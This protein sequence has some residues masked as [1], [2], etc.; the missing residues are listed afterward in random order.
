MRVI[1]VTVVDALSLVLALT[2]LSSLSVT[3]AV[4]VAIAVSVVAFLVDCCISPHRHGVAP[5]KHHPELVDVD[6][7]PSADLEDPERRGAVPVGEHPKLDLCTRSLKDLDRGLLLGD[8]EV[9]EMLG[10]AL[11]PVQRAALIVDK[12]GHLVLCQVGVG[13]KKSD[14]VDH[15]HA[16]DS[17]AGLSA[18]LSEGMY[19]VGPAVEGGLQDICWLSLVPISKLLLAIPDGV[20]SL[21]AIGWRG[22]HMTMLLQ[23]T[24]Q[25]KLCTSLCR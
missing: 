7:L 13:N 8:L 22:Q 18:G 17:S 9:I 4:S 16:D 11:L 24:H 1:L 12:G 23:L 19:T 10:V 25:T 5:L 2:S 20:P 15:V 3:V 21:A 6:E 14:K